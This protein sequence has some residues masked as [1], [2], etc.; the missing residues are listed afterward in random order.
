MAAL[1]VFYI[2]KSIKV[3]MNQGLDKQRLKKSNL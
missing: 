3:K 1:Q 2:L